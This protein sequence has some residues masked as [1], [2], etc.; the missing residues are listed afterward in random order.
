MSRPPHPP[1]FNYP[2]N[3]RWK[4]Q[5]VKFITMQ[6]YPRSVFSAFLCCYMREKILLLLI[7]INVH[8]MFQ[9]NS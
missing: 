8:C 5:A 3:I 4:I 2:N 7:R 6:F 1:W 9:F